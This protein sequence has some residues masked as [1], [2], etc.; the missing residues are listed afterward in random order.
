MARERNTSGDL[1]T[2][3]GTGF[4]MMAI[5]VAI[6]R[7]FI[8]RAEGLARTQKIVD[9]LQNNCTTY[10]GAFAHWINGG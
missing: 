6:K 8:T 7:N 2:S 4:G 3:G 5:P 1:V 9:F 10:H